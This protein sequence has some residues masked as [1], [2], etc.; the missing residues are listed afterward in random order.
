MVFIRNGNYIEEPSID[1]VLDDNFDYLIYRKNNIRNTL[2]DQDIIDEDIDIEELFK[3]FI[4]GNFEGVVEVSENIKILNEYYERIRD[5]QLS[6]ERDKTM[7]PTYMMKVIAKTYS[8]KLNEYEMLEETRKRFV[9]VLKGVLIKKKEEDRE[10]LEE[11]RREKILHDES[12]DR[13]NKFLN[14][15][16]PLGSLCLYDID[17]LRNTDT[18]RLNR[19]KII[20]YIRYVYSHLDPDTNYDEMMHIPI[21]ALPKQRKSRKH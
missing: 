3:E 1:E 7:N 11:E 4:N 14:K 8:D 13:I 18:Y 21:F 15:E 16:I 5:V 12:L 2:D 9:D 19:R 6:Y 20:K 17:V 10:R